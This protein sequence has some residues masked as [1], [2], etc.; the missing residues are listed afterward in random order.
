MIGGGE[1]LPHRR[2]RFRSDSVG[3]PG[4]GTDTASQRRTNTPERTERAPS[5]VRGIKKQDLPA[6]TCATC[7]RPFT[8]RKKW[9]R[10]WNEVRYCSDR[11]R[12]HRNDVTIGRSN[13]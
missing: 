9:A 8:W 6:K 3:Y 10:D 5:S 11:C 1:G 7:G 13:G 12:S 4:R 2:R